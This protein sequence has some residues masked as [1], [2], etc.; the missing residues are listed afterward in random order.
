MNEAFRKYIDALDPAF[1][2]LVSMEPCKVGSLPRSMP[3]KGV[4]L[5][6]EAGVHL[7]VGRSNRL[8]G[9]LQEHR[10]RSSDHYSATLAFLLARETTGQ[11]AAAYTQVGSR[12]DLVRDPA[13]ARAFDRG[14]ERIR[15]MDCRFVEEGDPVGQALLEM[16]VAVVLRTT[17]NDFDTH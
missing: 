9:R 14:K 17:Y 13:F 12:A 6:S 11:T 2:R 3:A 8:K 7:Y 1:Q 16:Y 10:R 15:N 5:L 4:Y